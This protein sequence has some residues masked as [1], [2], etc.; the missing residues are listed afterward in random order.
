MLGVCG[1]LKLKI[2]NRLGLSV[3]CM[4]SYF[5]GFLACYV[6][7]KSVNECISCG[8]WAATEEL[9][10]YGFILPPEVPEQF[11]SE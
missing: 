10:G 2:D 3:E 7:G 4:L 9:K 11:K 8:I 1:H 5:V 6:Q